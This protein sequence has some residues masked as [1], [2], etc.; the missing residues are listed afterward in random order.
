M[1]SFLR[2]SPP[3]VLVNPAAG[4][5]RVGAILPRIRKVFESLGI[6]AQFVATSSAEELE[7][8]ARHAIS[9][10]QRLLLAMGGDGTFQAL[11]NG[12]CGADVI[13]GALPVGG[14]NDF[15]TAL[16]IPRD[17]L[18]AA[19]ALLRG[20]PR[21]ADLVRARTADGRE[22]FYVGGGGVGSMPKRQPTPAVRI[23]IS[24][25]EFATL[26]QLCAR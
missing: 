12:V 1:W 2:E 3:L 17:P 15:A 10:N 5:G 25:A 7:S 13:V 26:P 14:G 8:A 18:K 22:R 4:G 24:P 21:H 6:S 16:G 23:V 20:R 19:G 11:A 9:Q